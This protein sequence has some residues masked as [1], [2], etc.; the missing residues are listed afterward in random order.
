MPAYVVRGRTREG[1]SPL[2]RASVV[3]VLAV[4]AVLG[5]LTSAEPGQG[6]SS[7]LGSVAVETT[8]GK[9]T[10]LQVY[11]G[12][13]RLQGRGKG[14]ASGHT[15]LSSSREAMTLAREPGCMAHPCNTTRALQP[16]NGANRT[17]VLIALCTERPPEEELQK[18]SC[19]SH[20]LFLIQKCHESLKEPSALV[21]EHLSA[22]TTVHDWSWC[23]MA[24]RSHCHNFYFIKQYYSRL[25]TWD[26]VYF[27]KGSHYGTPWHESPFSFKDI[28]PRGIG[29]EHLG[30]KVRPWT[31]ARSGSV[32]NKPF[33]FMLCG[34][35]AKPNHFHGSPRGNF[36][37]STARLMSWPECK[38][39]WLFHQLTYPPRGL[40]QTSQKGLWEF[41]EH[42]YAVLW[43][44]KPIVKGEWHGGFKGIDQPHFMCPRDSFQAIV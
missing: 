14:K 43:S 41:F 21:P 39:Q 29:F 16:N 7:R 42:M 19:D 33:M 32:W 34:V 28:R 27:L 22:C 17:A 24:G 12:S 1:Q 44:C 31:T 6:E 10:E 11:S 30:S 40:A 2:P 13:R 3:A 20:D 35:R 9:Q 38:Y 23:G 36:A 18:L 5:Q 8:S 25:P 26:S 37:V 15:V 4:V